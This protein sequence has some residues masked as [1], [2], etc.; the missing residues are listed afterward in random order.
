MTTYPVP[1]LIAKQTQMRS[2]LATFF[3]AAV[4]HKFLESE[5]ELTNAMVQTG[6]ICMGSARVLAE[7]HLLWPTPTLTAC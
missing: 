2:K 5:P 1:K 3:K 4:K 7:W 6:W